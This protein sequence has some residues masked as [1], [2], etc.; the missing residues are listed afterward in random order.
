[1][2]RLKCARSLCSRLLVSYSRSGSAHWVPEP[3]FENLRSFSR[4]DTARPVG[5]SARSRQRR[6]WRAAKL[7]RASSRSLLRRCSAGLSLLQEIVVGIATANH[8]PAAARAP[9]GGRGRGGCGRLEDLP[10]VVGAA[11]RAPQA[12]A[13]AV[14]A[15][16][17]ARVVGAAARAPQALALAVA[18]VRAPEAPAAAVSAVGRLRRRLNAFRGRRSRLAPRLRTACSSPSRVPA[19]SKRRSLVVAAASWPDPSRLCT[20]TT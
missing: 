6:D 13:L 5:K 10:A 12:L 14:A 18:A 16:R 1:M 17:C 4:L 2:L 20:Y 19:D 11:A 15:A 9:S 8:C 7:R 3:G